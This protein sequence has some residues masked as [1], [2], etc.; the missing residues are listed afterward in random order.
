[1]IKQVLVLLALGYLHLGTSFSPACSLRRCALPSKS[2]SKFD[3][4]ISFTNH[5]Q[6]CSRRF[7]K[8]QTTPLQEKTN[9]TDEDEST[10]DDS[11]LKKFG[12]PVAVAAAAGLFYYFSQ[13][14]D[15]SAM[16]EKLLSEIADMGIYGYIYFAL[17]YIAVD[18]LAIPAVA[19]TASSGYVFGLLNGT[20]MVI[21]CATI[22]AS[23]SFFI[24]RVFLRD[25]AQKY[26]SENPRWR[27]IDKAVAKEGF[28][29]ILLLRL[30]PLLPFALSNYVYGVTSVDF[31]SYITATFLG[32]TPGS[33]GVVYFG[34]AGKALLTEG[35]A[36]LPWYGYAGV[37]VAIL[38]FGQV[39]SKY[40]TQVIQEI[41]KEDEI[42]QAL[43]LENSQ[44]TIKKR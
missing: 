14:F 28:K 36:S 34:S 40:A 3:K 37:G 41:E 29:I 9:L 24:G 10:D 33:F 5:R 31:I 26:I 21:S 27:V 32:F 8:L 16:I 6:E 38:A 19:L 43:K 13:Q 25:W 11:P 17:A 1:M 30:S 2:L 7:A 22:A 35:G 15:V 12:T 44:K 42:E 23:V 20:L 18:I 39:V 4:S